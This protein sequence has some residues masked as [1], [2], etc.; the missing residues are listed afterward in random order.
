MG[1]AVKVIEIAEGT[2]S[3]TL[4]EGALKKILHEVPP[5]MEIAI[6]SVVGAFRTGKSFVLDFML[7]Y[8]KSGANSDGSSD[9]TQAWLGET[10]DSN[11]NQD[12]QR[13]T[14]AMH[15]ARTKKNNATGFGWRSGKERC[16]TGIWMWSDSFVRQ[17]KNGPVAVLLVDTQ[18][19]FDSTLS[20]MLTASIFGLSTLISSYQI[21]NVDKHI[22]EDH[23]Q[24]LALFTEYGRVALEESKSA[25]LDASKPFQRLEFLVRDWQ[26]FADDSLPIAQL[27]REMDSYLEEVLST[28]RDHVDLKQVREQVT[29]SFDSVSCFL[30]PHPGKDVPNINFDGSVDKIDPQFRRLLAE[31]VYRVFSDRLSPK[32]INGQPVTGPELFN[33]I[34]VYCQLFKEAKIFPEAKT[35]LAATSEANN[36]SAM[37]S[38]V[39]EYRAVMDEKTKKYL[40]EHELRGYHDSAKVVAHTAYNKKANIGPKE[41]IVEFRAKLDKDLERM[42]DEYSQVN[43]LRDPFGFVA[44]Y[45]VP[46]V[47]ALVCYAVKYVVDTFCWTE[48]CLKGTAFLQQI[49]ATVFFFML[50]HFLSMGHGIKNRLVA[51]FGIV[52]TAASQA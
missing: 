19:M 24:H 32:R 31:Y 34:K 42:S 8:L 40:E 12:V 25:G 23:L 3:F 5:D 14:E 49:Y 10:L 6:V 4:N 21:Y 22:Q 13:G 33:F 46:I 20:Q 51:M 2:Q 35:L 9:V 38:A 27:T 47:I 17:T 45:V 44:P 48:T 43:R 28:K 37:D 11:E 39:R 7:R 16:T 29:R 18:G 1:H 52:K 30:M 15:K 41:S 36:R 50:F 26:N